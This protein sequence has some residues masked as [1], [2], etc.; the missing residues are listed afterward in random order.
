MDNDSGVSHDILNIEGFLEAPNNNEYKID[1]QNNAIMHCIKQ[2][3]PR[4]KKP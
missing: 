2:I 1:M 3:R 4:N